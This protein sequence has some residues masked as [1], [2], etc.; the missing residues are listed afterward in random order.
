MIYS[1]V[2]RENQILCEADLH[3]GNYRQLINLVLQEKK[4]ENI[5]VIYQIGDYFVHIYNDGLCTYL[6]LTDAGFERRQ[7]FAFLIDIAQQFKKEI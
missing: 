4:P 7:C 3:T 1:R 5:K 6:V 2:S